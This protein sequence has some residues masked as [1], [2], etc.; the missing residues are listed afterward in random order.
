MNFVYIVRMV[1]NW[2][3]NG[4]CIQCLNGK[5]GYNNYCFNEIQNCIIYNYFKEGEK[6]QFVIMDM[7]QMKLN[8]SNAGM[9]I[10]Q[11]EKN[12]LR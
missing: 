9:V 8:V 10:I 5:I 12:A 2:M 11:M 6:C 1:I 7:N 4:K 3:K